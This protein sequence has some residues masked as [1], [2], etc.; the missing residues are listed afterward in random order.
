[1]WERVGKRAAEAVKESK[2]EKRQD[3]NKTSFDKRYDTF[4][5]ETMVTV[6]LLEEKSLLKKVS[7]ILFYSLD[8]RRPPNP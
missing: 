4:L 8:Q 5:N 6:K 2:E 1:M 3:D 7:H